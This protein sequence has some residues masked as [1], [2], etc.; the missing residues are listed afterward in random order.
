M[1]KPTDAYA[2]LLAGGTAPPAII[3]AKSTQPS[4]VGTHD[5][6]DMEGALEVG[7]SATAKSDPVD[8]SARAKV[9]TP[10]EAYARLTDKKGNDSLA[11]DGGSASSSNDSGKFTTRFATEQADLSYINP[12][13]T[14]N[15]QLTIDTTKVEKVIMPT[16]NIQDIV[17]QLVEKANQM[18]HEGKTDTTI[19][20]K[21]PPILAG[22]NLVVTAFDNARGEFNISF[23]NLTQAAKNL[24]DQRLNQESLR[25]AL[26][27]KGYAVHI[28]TTTTL[29]ERLV[30]D[31]PP[32]AGSQSDRQ[33][34]G[35]QQQGRPRQNKED[36]G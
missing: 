2:K 4:T 26:Q 29:T 16:A 31:T 21:Q 7:N 10:A 8:A 1:A 36:Q 5:K 32:A 24:L 30:L 11:G 18:Q 14:T 13:A 22:A 27:E 12:L 28:V 23:E 33:R 35:N 34:G 17:N 19:T 25:L 6:G 20:L 9:E 15:H 3:K